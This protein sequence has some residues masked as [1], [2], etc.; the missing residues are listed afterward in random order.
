MNIDM[1][2][3]EAFETSL[4]EALDTV[5]ALKVA[6]KNSIIT[7]YEKSHSQRAIRRMLGVVGC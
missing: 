1:K 2:Q 6:M 7:L 3:F 5:N 4:K